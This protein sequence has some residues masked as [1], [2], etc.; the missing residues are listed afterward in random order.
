[1]KS[2]NQ[3]SG[4]YTITADVS[5]GSVMGS[6]LYPL[7]TATNLPSTS[8]AKLGTFGD[9]TAVLPAMKPPSCMKDGYTSHPYNIYVSTAQCPDT[10]SN[11]PV[12]HSDNVRYLGLTINM[13]TSYRRKRKKFDFNIKRLHRLMELKF[14]LSFIKP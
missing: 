8:N 5:Q 3:T 7:F 14:L 1:M 12:P 4:L 9:D 11:V 13:K 2:G 6:I 10:I